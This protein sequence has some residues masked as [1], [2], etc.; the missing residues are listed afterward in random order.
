[1][2]VCVC[3]GL[4]YIKE[5]IEDSNYKFFFYERSV[6]TLS[7]CAEKERLWFSENFDCRKITICKNTSQWRIVIKY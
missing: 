4:N 2:C 3:V 5:D 1:M 7:Y 6:V